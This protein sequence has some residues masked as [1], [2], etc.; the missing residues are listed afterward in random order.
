M[1]IH[2]LTIQ[3]VGSETYLQESTHREKLEGNRVE[4]KCWRKR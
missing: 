4:T 1:V 2:K 3:T